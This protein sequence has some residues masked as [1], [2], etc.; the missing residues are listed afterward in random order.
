VLRI[1]KRIAADRDL[2]I[3]FGNLTDC[4]PMS[5]SRMSARTVSESMRRK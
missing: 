2:G 4:I 5:P 3:G 1:E